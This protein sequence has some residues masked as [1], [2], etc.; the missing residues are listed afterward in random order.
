MYPPIVD[1]YMPAYLYGSEYYRIYV[2]L[3]PYMSFSGKI[4]VHINVVNQKTNK[5]ALIAQDTFGLQLDGEIRQEA[6]TGLYYVDLENNKYN[7]SPYTYYKV[8]FRTAKDSPR[9]GESAQAYLTRAIYS[10]WSTACLIK[11]IKKPTVELQYFTNATDQQITGEIGTIFPDSAVFVSGKVTFEDN[12]GSNVEYLKNYQIKFF[13]NNNT[14]LEESSILS[15]LST[16]IDEINYSSKYNFQANTIY[17]MEIT[18]LSSSLY[19]WKE[20]YNFVVTKS[21]S[22]DIDFIS[23]LALDEENGKIHLGISFDINQNNPH[24]NEDIVIYI[25]RADS[26]TDYKYWEDVYSYKTIVTVGGGFFWEDA[27]VESGIWYKYAIQ[28]TIDGIRHGNF[29]INDKSL[30]LFENNFLIGQDGQT[31]KLKYDTTVDSYTYHQNTQITETIGSKY[32]FIRQN[33]AMF[34]RSF[35]ISGLIT[36]LTETEQENSGF[37]NLAKGNGK[38]VFKHLSNEVITQSSDSTS[39]CFISKQELYKTQQNMQDYENYF[40]QNDIT[41]YNNFIQ[42]RFYREEVLNFLL[43]SNVKLFKSTTEGNILVQLSEVSFTPKTELGRYIYSFSAKATEC[44]EATIENYN[45]Y[46]IQKLSNKG[47][48][49]LKPAYTPEIVDTEVEIPSNE[50]AISLNGIVPDTNIKADIENSYPVEEDFSIYQIKFYS[51]GFSFISAPYSVNTQKRIPEN[52]DSENHELGYLI[53]IDNETYFIPASQGFIRFGGN[54][55]ELSISSITFPVSTDVNII[56]DAAVTYLKSE[57]NDGTDTPV[58]YIQTIVE[59]YSA[60]SHE[61]SSG[62]FDYQDDI[63]ETM[64]EHYQTIYH[65][66]IE[67]DVFILNTYSIKITGADKGTVFTMSDNSGKYIHIIG[68]TG[69]LNINL[70]ANL[71]DNREVIEDAQFEGTL[72]VWEE[73]SNISDITIVFAENRFG[74]GLLYSESEGKWIWC[75]NNHAYDVRFLLDLRWTDFATITTNVPLSSSNFKYLQILKPI[76]IDGDVVAKVKVTTNLE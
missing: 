6:E 12:S 19:E 35:N 63:I 14:V 52:G 61:Y 28:Y 60:K 48:A 8:Q 50:I 22:S 68:P 20:N 31:Y 65:H 40:Q 25:R 10:E 32:P 54:D 59:Q 44:A 9:T 7:F 69:S 16:A 55:T 73:N 18:F 58:N 34:Y 62:I 26:K 36:Y 2:Q 27:T 29:L 15:P 43:D 3:S 23:D 71:T 57:V 4:N 47:Y 33:G 64:K 21:Q 49:L 56:M 70:D 38:S 13:D 45:L 11:F 46:K 24:L 30:L 66:E 39:A 41:D 17:K 76:N 67:E 42:E 1:T 72:A 5:S 74:Y 51:I 53:T 37:T 75:E